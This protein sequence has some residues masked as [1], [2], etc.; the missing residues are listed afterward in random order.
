MPYKDRISAL[1][2]LMD[3]EH[4]SAVIVPSDDPHM[5]EYPPE[6]FKVRRFLTGFTGSAGTAVILSDTWGLWTDGRYYIQAEKQIAPS[7]GTLFKSGEPSCPGIGDYLV[8]ALPAGSVVSI[9]GDVCSRRYA[10]EME[11]KLA[12]GGISLR[13]DLSLAEEVWTDR[14]SVTAAPMWSAASGTSCS[15][16]EKLQAVREKMLPEATALLTG[17]LDSTAWLFNIRAEDIP[18]V[19]VPIAW[20]LVTREKATLFTDLSRIPAQLQDE[21]SSAGVELAA[22][23]AVAAALAGLPR[24]VLQLEPAEINMTLWNLAANNPEVSIL[25]GANPIPLLKAVKDPLEIENTKAAYLEDCVALAEFYAELERRLSSGDSIDEYEATQML[26]RCR[27]SRPTYLTPSFAPIAA[28]RENAAM[29]HY[30]PSPEAAKVLSGPGFFLLDSGGHYRYGT[31]DITRT[32]PLCPVSQEERSDYTTVVKGFIHLH[33]AV[34]KD[35]MTGGDLDV[36]CRVHLWRQLMDYRCGTGHGV[37]FVLNIHEGPQG[38]GAGARNTPLHSGMY[39]TIEPGI[40]RED[41][42][43]IRCEN[44]VYIR[45]YGQSEYGNFLCFEAFTVL[46]IDPA[47]LLVD[48][49]DR[50]E[51]MWLNGYNAH[52]REALLP[53]LSPAAAEWVRAHTTPIEA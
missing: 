38:F 26:E 28:F 52:V 40:Y 15:V 17:R 37:G 4:V 16:K 33:T 23:D 42:W 48:Q 47:P 39:L 30:A 13:F 27:R 19:P 7:G 43:G 46:P 35:G 53:H 24:T 3:K 12:K 41:L 1:R 2:N 36:L 18:Y 31:T 6:R 29:M 45:P 11:E 34:F 8:S 20:S 9:N 49:L 51:I 21:L 5:S 14:P 32:Y 25:E 10:G 44:A 50:S 22:Y